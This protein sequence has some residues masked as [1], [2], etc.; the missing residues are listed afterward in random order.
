MKKTIVYSFAF[1]AMMAAAET[2]AESTASS[3]A[4]PKATITDLAQDDDRTVMINYSLANAPAVVTFTAETNGPNGWVALEGKCLLTAS[5]DIFRRVDKETGT[6]RWNVDRMGLEEAIASGNLRVNL[7]AW[8]LDDTPDYMVV[9]LAKYG[10]SAA[11]R[12]RYYTSTNELLGGLL[13]NREYRTSHVV[14]K[15]M[16]ARGIR[17]MMGSPGGT[18]G[19]NGNDAVTGFPPETMHPVTLTNDYY[20]GVFPLTVA[21]MAAINNTGES[22]SEGGFPIDRAMR[23]CDRVYY[24]AGSNFIMRDSNWPKPPAAGSVLGKLRTLTAGV[25]EDWEL[26]SEAQWE[27]AAR[28][29]Q[30]VMHW[31]DGTEYKFFD[32]DSS[33]NK[34]DSDYG[35]PG[36][37]RYNQANDWHTKWQDYS[38]NAKRTAQGPESGTPIA[39]S[40]A[41]NAYGLYDMH[42]GIWEWCLDWYQADITSLNGAVNIN[43]NGDLPF[44]GQVHK[45]LMPKK[46]ENGEFVKDENGNTVYVAEEWPARVM[47]GGCYFSD[48]SVC[49]ASYRRSSKPKYPGDSQEGGARLCC[50]AGLK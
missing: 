36:R 38:D 9:S 5:G 28:A 16:H 19:R 31:G 14:M 41:P 48:A 4:V 45:S 6:I 33:G 21:Q 32:S 18:P 8:R 30:P 35:M 23:I 12:V 3:V 22:G 2:E 40:Y 1:A 17:W 49:R 11:D 24:D 15:R 26:P 44:N 13:A 43:E 42:G 29:N 10:I 34:Y 20:I 25:I 27:F 50:R 7:T 46:D 39:G 47:R 37:Y